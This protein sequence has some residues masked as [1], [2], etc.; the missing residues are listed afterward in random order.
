MPLSSKTI[1]ITSGRSGS[2]LLIQSLNKHPQLN[3]T[4]EILNLKPEAIPPVPR[5]ILTSIVGPLPKTRHKNDNYHVPVTY[6]ERL[7]EEFDGFK[8]LYYELN[9]QFVEYLK[10]RP[11]I[12]IVH[13][14]R[15]N[16]LE[17]CVSKIFASATKVYHIK[18]GTQHDCGS[19]TISAK[20]LDRKMKK[21]VRGVRQYSD[22]FGNPYC[23]FYEDLVSSWDETMKDLQVFMGL[24]PKTLPMVSNK[25][26]QRPLHHVVKNYQELHQHFAG[27]EFEKFFKSQILHL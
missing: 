14:I 18:A 3:L 9:P 20:D 25:V 17:C 13:L 16:A 11:D 27:T 5:E 6:L 23:V 24:E 7:L 26:I 10:S 12:K 19:I 15:Q 2:N 4:G 22:L 21:H 8:M 1:V